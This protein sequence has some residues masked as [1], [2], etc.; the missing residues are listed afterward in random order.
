M[1]TAPISKILSASLN[2]ISGDA[3]QELKFARRQPLFFAQL[4][5]VVLDEREERAIRVAASLYL[6][7]FLNENLKLGDETL[8]TEDKAHLKRRLLP[9]IVALAAMREDTLRAQV[10]ECV[11]LLAAVEFPDSW[12]SLLEQ[13]TSNLR[14]D[15]I[16]VVLGTLETARAVFRLWKDRAPS[17]TLFNEMGLVLHHFLPPFFAVFSYAA[18]IVTVSLDGGFIVD[19][20]WASLIL[21]LVDILCDIIQPEM[22]PMIEEKRDYLFDAQHGH[23]V[24][25]LQCKMIAGSPSTVLLC[26]IREIRV[27]IFEIAETFARRYPD[28]LPSRTVCILNYIIW[29]QLKNENITE[30][31]V[32]CALK[33]VSS[34]IRASV[35]KPIFSSV[36]AISL[37]VEDFAVPYLS[38]CDEDL[39]ELE[40][41][42]FQF[43]RREFTATEVVSPRMAARDL[44]RAL[45]TSGLEAQTMEVAMKAI[46][47]GLT[48]GDTTSCHSW[49]G[50]NQMFSLYEC[51][52]AP[53]TTNMD[54]DATLN[55]RAN[56]PVFFTMCVLPRLQAGGDQ[57]V[58]VILDALRSLL[59]VH[60]QIEPED[61]RICILPVIELLNSPH[62]AIHTYAAAVIGDILSPPDSPRLNL[63]ADAMRAVDALTRILNFGFVGHE[64]SQN[65]TIARCLTRVV[66]S[67]ESDLMHFSEEILSSICVI[68]SSNLA[69]PSLPDFYHHL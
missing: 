35:Y 31:I 34:A 68:L 21:V 47:T 67:L 55:P 27:R 17:T 59:L 62:V 66:Q 43:V 57:H 11:S 23:L 20:T 42:P 13:I 69:N 46:T 33:F 8:T 64:E 26:K 14:V 32:V 3:E 4:L 9:A 63:G 45:M 49:R 65:Y 5:Q 58:I 39:E 38:L 40:E 6:K 16:N 15:N 53:G 22:P 19:E 24:H 52:V 10:S 54:R 61:L 41:T 28:L 50:H 7:N 2:D 44:I 25:L 48:T 36:E 29:E 12:K 56:V 51:I 18:S 30:E 37:I 60:R 1:N